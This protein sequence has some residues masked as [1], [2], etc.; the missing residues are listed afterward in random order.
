MQFF[1]NEA[2]VVFRRLSKNN[3]AFLLHTKLN[4]QMTGQK[5]N[6]ATNQQPGVILIC[7][8]GAGLS[9]QAVNGGTQVVVA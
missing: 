8:A 9:G 1:E 7:G 5:C 6:K 4:V 3:S 2:L